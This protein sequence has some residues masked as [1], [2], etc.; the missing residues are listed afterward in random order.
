MDL[1]KVAVTSKLC[2]W[3]GSRK[4]AEPDILKN[5]NFKRPKKEDLPQQNTKNIQ[6]GNYCVKN[7]ESG[8]VILSK[9]K[10]LDLKKIAPNAVFFTGINLDDSTENI[11]FISQIDTAD[12]TNVTCLPEPLTSLFDGTAVN[13]EN[14]T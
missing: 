6:A 11:D 5:I 4:S 2:K 14:M 13:L 7:F 3:N 9:E 12:E 8:I 1:N 10:I